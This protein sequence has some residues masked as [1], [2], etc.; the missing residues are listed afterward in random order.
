M[1]H[2]G[3]GHTFSV[4]VSA[5]MAYQEILIAITLSIYIIDNPLQPDNGISNQFI[6][7]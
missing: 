3:I 1:N 4:Q 7:F 5:L 2:S 6:I